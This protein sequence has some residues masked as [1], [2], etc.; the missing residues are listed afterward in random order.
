MRCDWCGLEAQFRIV[1]GCLDNH[2]D[3]ATLCSS[4]YLKFIEYPYCHWCN[5]RKYAYMKYYE[6]SKIIQ[7]FEVNFG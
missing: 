7:M 2:I 1:Y 4:C 3:N 6:N 5:G